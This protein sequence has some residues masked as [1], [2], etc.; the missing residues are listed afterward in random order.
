MDCEKKG[1]EA[2]KMEFGGLGGF[3]RRFGLYKE[4]LVKSR[5]GEGF[6]GVMS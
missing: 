2:E 1:R 6:I 3:G 5:G 4:K